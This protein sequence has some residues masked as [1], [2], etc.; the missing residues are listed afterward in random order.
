MT[1]LFGS[2]VGPPSGGKR[3][4][5]H[6]RC[7]QKA[8]LQTGVTLIMVAGVL[9]VLAALGAGFYSMML[10]QSKS[11][12][13]F[14][15]AVS[16]ELAMRAGMADAV[17]RMREEVIFHTEDP[18]SAWYTVDYLHGA[19][20][21]ISFPARNPQSVAS[22]DKYFSFTRSVS[23]KIEP[24]SEQ[25]SLSIVD[26]ASKI[27]INAGDNLGVILDNLCRI[28]GAPLTAADPD[29]IQPRCWATYGASAGMFDNTKNA[30]D[31]ADFK[32]VDLYYP[33]DMDRDGKDDKTGKAMPTKPDGSALY[34]DG[35]AIAA[36]RSKHGKFADIFEVKNALTC[37]LNPQH[38]E[39][40][41]L[42]IEVKF[43][44]IRN[45]ITVDS[46]VDTST[47]C[48]GKF[49]WVSPGT[50]SVQAVDPDSTKT[51]GGAGSLDCQILIDRDK[52]WVA[53]D[54]QND[55]YNHRGSLRGCYLAIVNGHGAGQLRRIATN[56][57]DWIAVKGSQNL[58]V[59]PGPISSYMIVAKEDALVENVAVPTSP[60]GVATLP[61]QD[62]QGGLTDDPNIDYSHY[63]LCIH[64]A[65]VN[66]NTASDKVLAALF[67]GIDIQHGHPMAVGTDA[68]LIATK[69]AWKYT[70]GNGNAY[71]PHDIWAYVLR[72][73]GMKRI[74]ASPG[75]VTL[76]RPVPWASGDEANYGYIYNFGGMNATNFAPGKSGVMNE[77]QE[78]A[79]RVIM[80]RTRTKLVGTSDPDPTTA[81]A[82]DGPAPYNSAFGGF[83]RGPF[84]SWDDLYFRVVKPWDDIRSGYFLTGKK[85]I[86]NSGGSKEGG[87][88]RNKA[89]VARMIMANFNPNTDIL[90]FNPNIEWIDRWG[91]NYTDM[92]PVM[93][94]TDQQ[95][96]QTSGNACRW[97]SDPTVTSQM[98]D[99]S[100]PIFAYE[101]SSNNARQV[102]L[103]PANV[104]SSGDIN[105]GVYIIRNF[106]YRSDEMIDKTDLNRSTT[107]F[108]FDSKGM[109][110]LQSIGRVVKAGQ[111]QAER[112]AEALI[113]IYD[114]WRETTQSQFVKGTIA[115]GGSAP[116]CKAG[117]NYAGQIARDSVNMN[118]LLPLVTLPEP[119]V[120][121]QYRI[122]NSKGL[123]NHEVVDSDIHGR[124]QYGAPKPDITV[125]DVVNNRVLPAVYDGQITLASNTL[126]FDPSTGGDHD[127]FLASF[128][129][130]LDTD[131]CVGNGR[132]QAKKPHTPAN[133]GYKYRVVDTCGLLG[134]MN[135]TLINIDTD[136]P[137]SPAGF[138]W[139][140]SNGGWNGWSAPPPGQHPS[141]FRFNVLTYCLRALNPKNYWENVT[142]RQ[143]DLRTDGVWLSCPGVSGNEATLKY[144]FGDGK[145]RAQDT[146]NPGSAKLNF[147]PGSA[148]GNLVTMWMKP[149]WH[150]N[151]R[152][153]HPLFD[154]TNPG[155]SEGGTSCR[156]CYLKKHGLFVCTAEGANGQGTAYVS[157][158]HHRTD[159]LNFSLEG[160]DMQGG[161]IP[162][163]RDNY[164]DLDLTI[165]LHGGYNWVPTR[166]LW[167]NPV[168]DPNI[169]MQQ[170]A[171]Q[172]G[173][174][175]EAPMYRVQ[176]FRWS[177]VGMRW[178]FHADPGLNGNGDGHWVSSDSSIPQTQ[179]IVTKMGRP[180]ISTQTFPETTGGIDSAKFPAQY[181]AALPN[182]HSPM[183]GFDAPPDIGDT[184]YVNCQ[185]TGTVT[186]DTR[187]DQGDYQPQSGFGCNGQPAKWK[188][189]DPSGF[190]DPLNKVFSIN[191]TN[192]DMCTWI[193]HHLPEDGTYAVIDELKISS[194]ER[195]LVGG[196]YSHDRAVMESTM[197]RY[198]MPPH[199][200]SRSDCPTFTSQ[201]M[202]DSTKG[203]GAVIAATDFV[204]LARVSWTVFT[205]RFM[206]E[207]I[208][209]VRQRQE[210]V[211][212]DKGTQQMQNDAFRGPFDYDKYNEVYYPRETGNIFP[213][214]VD[215]PTP[216]DYNP[217][218]SPTQYT[219]P[220][221]NRGVEVELLNDN[222]VV[223][224][225]SETFPASGVYS[226]NG[227]TFNNPDL[228]NRFVDKGGAPIT[229]ARVQPNKL[230]YRV[231][232][233]YPVDQ[234]VDPLAGTKHGTF[235]WAN[236]NKHYLL[237]T[238]V[239]DDISVTYYTHPQI[240]SYKE[241]G[242]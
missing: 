214:G 160:N 134:A 221:Y 52:S 22:N 2:F 193:Y 240:L 192:Q 148:D 58:Y 215:R 174:H 83:E 25:Y 96:N 238:P 61:K 173:Q 98:S 60:S 16:A 29:A 37:T 101:D 79:W 124:D 131:T 211:T 143:G 153:T 50:V 24:Y 74:P 194:R 154:A 163:Q 229:N 118:N 130:D 142:L 88:G 230:R 157:G 218:N 225:S 170:W 219:Q 73:R 34:G 242:E 31:T 189:A 140:V 155:Y 38:P 129:G 152:H 184:G 72:P 197:S 23:S 231:R 93:A 18:S 75:R 156:A 95:P 71:D 236:P 69:M 158:C 200:E 206:H 195:A 46:W 89:S 27:N 234:L 178:R 90:K 7:R 9:S 145:T 228:I 30:N 106:R 135:D 136:L 237:D 227:G 151:D 223:S 241:I 137:E 216:K 187:K 15:D 6:A 133:D 116:L 121:L 109:F 28:V 113:K 80:A 139:T 47:V 48:T 40:Q 235:F 162:E 182:S 233:R 63:P 66:I 167:H 110:E 127:T 144:C 3:V 49:E 17:A 125:P 87:I 64:R 132:E 100:R 138:Q 91:R 208:Q 196:D 86:P 213:Y 33:L 70:D 13:R 198:Y 175:E 185:G 123:A 147:N 54:P 76:D 39:L 94:Y 36:Y 84:K 159:D 176:P 222:K 12:T 4:E 92:E 212:H 120:P 180:F 128:N 111:T 146:D 164:R 119:L 53:D 171:P 205:P 190:E 224:G 150:H 57:I 104:T 43:D 188:W 183:H 199:P 181:W 207:N 203:E 172:S 103:T 232:F 177:Y 42:E 102:T 165:F 239:F 68:D 77:A 14:S 19:Q 1:I 108:A 117:T 126:G 141:V 59:A 204:T 81:D 209:L 44:A 67:M 168:S 166:F 35:Y 191:N 8:G 78:L 169:Q 217:S 186:G 11:A 56:G 99:S 201:T 226:D 21:N 20:R 45:F 179:G 85:T 114:V 41:M 107:E 32:N 5:K 51:N 55:P 105:A 202:S 149:T 82:G 161:Q 115:T 220:H 65:P 210:F 26:S 97:T 10:S 62:A 112:G 122:V